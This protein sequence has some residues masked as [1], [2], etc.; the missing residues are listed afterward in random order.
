MK[1]KWG[2]LLVSYLIFYYLLISLVS[3]NRWRQYE[4]YYYDHGI[5]DH[6]LWKA[7]HFQLPLIDHLESKPL[8]QLGD[9]FTPG[10]YIL[11]SAY[12]TTSSYEAIFWIQNLFVIGSAWILSRI[13]WRNTQNRFFTAAVIFSYTWFIGMQ[14]AIIAGFHT[15]LPGL[16]FLSLVLDALDRKMWRWFGIWL[17]CLLL[18]KESFVAIAAGLGVYLFFQKRYRLGFITIVGSTVYYMLVTRY[19]MPILA[20]RA[21]EY[22]NQ[23]SF[24]PSLITDF[25]IP[26]IKI[27]TVTVSLLTYGLLPL[28]TPSYLP[29][30]FQDWYIRFVLQAG[31]ARQD[32][33]MHY[34]AMVGLLLAYGAVLGGKKLIHNFQLP[35]FKQTVLLCLSIILFGT[36]IYFHQIKFHGPLGLGY[37]PAFYRHSD[38]FEFLNKLIEAVPEKGLVMTQNNLAVKMTHKHQLMLLRSGYWEYMPDYLVL[39]IRDGQNPNNYWPLPTFEWKELY[40]RLSLDPNYSMEAIGEE[41]VIFVKKTEVHDSW[42]EQ[43]KEI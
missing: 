42:Y 36:N 18:M 4:V 30:I 8:L 38:N 17:F 31:A 21:Y 12:W 14:N 2:L 27:K 6:A 25:F 1:S 34:N 11:S 26:S 7:A 39:D 13:S 24:S 37:N 5:F 32:L 40:S 28:L 3:I 20:G 9:H 23:I 29:V 15:E 41:Q 22:T 33:G 43:F 35:I 16:L 10:M 19:L